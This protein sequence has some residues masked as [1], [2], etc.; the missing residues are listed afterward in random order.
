MDTVLQRTEPTE[1]VPMAEVRSDDYGITAFRSIFESSPCGMLLVDQGGRI[2]RANLRLL[3]MFGFEEN[4]LLGELIEV[5]LPHRYR[6][7]HVAIRDGYAAAPSVRAMGQGRDLTGRRKDGVEFPLEIGL[8]PIQTE[9]G[10]MTCVS[11][12]DITERKRAELRL[13]DANA[14]LEEFTYVAS[15][16]LR[17]PLRGIANLVNIIREDY[18]EQAPPLVTRNL[19]RVDERVGSMEKVISDLLAYARAGRRTV[20]VEPIALRKLVEDVVNLQG[21]PES[22]RIE[23][24]VPD[25]TFDG[26]HTP[27]ETV[28]RNLL[29]NA[30]KHHDREDGEILIR[31]RLEGNICRIDV[32]DDG[33]GIPEAAQARVFR[34]FQTLG[35][36]QRKDAGLGLAVVQRLV[37]GH[38]GSI[39]LHSRDGVRGTTFRVSW[40]RFARTDLDD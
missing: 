12:I 25:E 31:A 3:A 24:D 23:I 17:S 40:P 11:I 13:R 32:R 29:S 28:V 2:A 8:S 4:E 18:G 35:T 1:E 6:S 30:I 16:D 36:S 38:G 22:M 39:I 14:Q 34:L 37:E 33:P 27:L 5:L 20:K 7:G 19:N 21:A 15:H 9:T 26:A 10:R